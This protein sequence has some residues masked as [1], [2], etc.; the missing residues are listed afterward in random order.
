MTGSTEWSTGYGEDSSMILPIRDTEN[1]FEN[2]TYRQT[3][4]ITSGSP[5]VSCMVCRWIYLKRARMPYI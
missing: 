4:T 2:G 3:T 1:P 5:S